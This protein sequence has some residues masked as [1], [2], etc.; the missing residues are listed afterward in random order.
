MAAASIEGITI[1]IGVDAKDLKKEVGEVTDD[2]R[3][4]GTAAETDLKPA[5][6]T[7][8]TLKETF[9]KLKEN[10]VW[11][12]GACLSIGKSITGWVKGAVEDA[13][14]VNPETAKTLEGVKTSF[15]GLKTSVGESLLPT[16]ERVAPTLTGALDTAAKFI[17]DH[18]DLSGVIMNVTAAIG[19]LSVALAVASPILALFGTS[20]AAVAGPVLLAGGVI[21]GLISIF[22]LLSDSIE[23]ANSAVNQ[24]NGDMDSVG[25]TQ[26]VVEDRLGHLVV[27][28][29]EYNIVPVWDEEAGDF[30]EQLARW[31]EN[32]LD[33]LTGS[34]G[35]YVTQAEDLA[36]AVSETTTALQNQADV[37]DQTNLAETLSD[38]VTE[39]KTAAD[40]A[41]ELLAS[42][43]TSME[44]LATTTG[45]DFADAMDQVN[46]VIESEA[47][48]QLSKQPVSEEVQGSW[49]ALQE[50][51]N[52]AAG[53]FT[54]M[55]ETLSDGTAAG[56]LD[57]IGGS[58]AGAAANFADLA[59]QI[60]L[61]I[62]A[63]K[64]LA[65]VNPGRSGGGGLGGSNH[66]VEA[67]AGGG[68]VDEDSAYLVGELEPEIF[69][70]HTS[71]T[72]VPMSELTGGGTTY[73]FNGDF[74]GESYLKRFVVDTFDEVIRK[75]KRLA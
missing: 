38:P 28:D 33:P 20:L 4:I 39:T 50:S 1:K 14:A 41:N 72:V 7:V 61:V 19:G 35:Y 51:V 36:N 47:F 27:E 37:V 75:E 59:A 17:N 22:A 52:L 63:Y 66:V 16:I 64:D 29:Y 73:N 18:P 8:N 46:Q 25:A 54:D 70:P 26:H 74:F 15:D 30:I 71:G 11:V 69:I 31:D 24:F 10:A 2:I 9:G 68:P 13:L 53:G 67:R 44:G 5:N 3:G 62:S 40:E 49:A 12:A 34:W 57:G 32:V 43:Q 65:G 55:K 23:E 45:T 6:T 21:V 48:Q 56:F 42:M 58:A 60:N